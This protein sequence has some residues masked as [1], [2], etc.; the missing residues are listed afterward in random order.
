MSS[1]RRRNQPGP[2]PAAVRERAEAIIERIDAFC[3]EHLDDEYAALSRKLVGRL[4]R[5]RPSP[6]MRGQ[7]RTWAASVIYF[8]GQA[9]F[10]SDPAQEPHLTTNELS[11]RTGV[12]KSTLSAKAKQIQDLL[13]LD[14]WDRELYRSELLLELPIFWMVEVDGLLVDART[15]PPAVQE[16]LRRRGF[17]PD[18]PVRGDAQVAEA[19]KP[20][21]NR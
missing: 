1:T 10:L 21:A 7:V 5:K 11:E 4:A 3:A 20:D 12:S 19:R 14:P 6:L 2:L 9:N 13:R 17:I 15:L 18:L 16:E 8:I